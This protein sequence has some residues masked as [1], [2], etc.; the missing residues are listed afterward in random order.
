LHQAKPWFEYNQDRKVNYKTFHRAQ[1]Q[2]DGGH[3]DNFLQHVGAG[4]ADVYQPHD[5]FLKAHDTYTGN[6]GRNHRAI[7]LPTSTFAFTHDVQHALLT[8]HPDLHQHHKCADAAVLCTRNA[9]VDDFYNKALNLKQNKEGEVDFEVQPIQTLNAITKVKTRTGA[10]VVDVH[11]VTDE[12]LRMCDNPGARC[13]QLPPSPHGTVL[14]L[15]S[16]TLR[17]FSCCL[18]SISPT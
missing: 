17:T 3:Y 10:D 11:V 16:F 5:Q 9:T 14:G 18:F 15:H 1:Q 6:F 2:Q 13:T 4:S 12:F 8:A 7:K